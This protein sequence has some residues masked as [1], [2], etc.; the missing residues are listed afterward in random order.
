MCEGGRF[1]MRLFFFSPQLSYSSD[2]SANAVKVFEVLVNYLVAEHI[3]YAVELGLL[4]ETDGLV[5]CIWHYCKH[6]KIIQWNSS[7]KTIHL[8]ACI[9]QCYKHTGTSR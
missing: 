3:D 5:V 6:A 1:G 8:V 4:G 2:L 7:F 9:W